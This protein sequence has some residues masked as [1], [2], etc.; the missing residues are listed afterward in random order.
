MDIVHYSRPYGQGS[1]NH[2]MEQE[3]D[4][5]LFRQDMGGTERVYFNKDE[6]DDVFDR[7]DEGEIR[8]HGNYS[9]LYAS[10]DKLLDEA[11]QLGC[12]A[13]IGKKI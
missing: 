7:I 10:T 3:F 13:T 1:D 5:M 6:I 2:A 4:Y 8:I 9:I 11:P 12:Y